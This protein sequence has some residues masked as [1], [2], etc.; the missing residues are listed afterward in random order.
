MKSEILFVLYLTFL[1][2]INSLLCVPN[3][4]VSTCTGEW[5][6]DGDQQPESVGDSGTRAVEVLHA[7]FQTSD[8]D[9][10]AEQSAYERY[11]PHLGEI[12]PLKVH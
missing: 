12:R 5:G 9:G 3:F 4:F 8:F 2:Q 7:L 1:V 11:S 6:G 10:N